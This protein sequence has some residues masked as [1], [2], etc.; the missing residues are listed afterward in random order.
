MGNLVLLKNERM[1]RFFSYFMEKGEDTGSRIYFF[2]E[3]PFSAYKL[4]SP[5]SNLK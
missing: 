4:A 1:E 2:M 3:I 5:S